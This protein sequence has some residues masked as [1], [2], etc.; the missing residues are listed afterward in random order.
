MPRK[1]KP[2]QT[3]TGKPKHPGGRPSKYTPELGRRIC[4]AIATSTDGLPDICAAHDDFPVV[5]TIYEWRYDH[6]EFSEWYGLARS[7]QADLM[8]EE[9]DAIAKDG[10]ND[11]MEKHYK[12]HEAWVLNGEAV[13]R[14]RLRIDTIK[15]KACK[16]LPKLYGDKA[17]PEETKFSDEEKAELRGIMADLMVKHEREY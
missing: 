17:T 9:M 8:I 10:H 1:A 2:Q 14:S 3:D 11:W 16:L 15:W 13:A 4:R 7:Q 6:P 12:D 5:S